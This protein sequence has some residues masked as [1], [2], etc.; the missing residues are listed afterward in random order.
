M[1]TNI[2]SCTSNSLTFT[3]ANNVFTKCCQEESDTFY[4]PTYISKY[5]GFCDK[6]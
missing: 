2:Y 3:T 6:K 1:Q 4:V 5:N